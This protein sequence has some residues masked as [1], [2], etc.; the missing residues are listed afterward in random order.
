MEGKWKTDRDPGKSLRV[1]Q[2][3]WMAGGDPMKNAV[4]LQ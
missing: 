3:Q 4:I 2:A 1:P